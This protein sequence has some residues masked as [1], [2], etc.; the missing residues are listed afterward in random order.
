MMKVWGKVF[1][2]E[3][4]V[5]HCVVEVNP[6]VST[7]FDMIKNVCESL[8]I[9]TPVILKKHVLDFNQFSMTLFKPTDFV[10]NFVFDRVII[11][12]LSEE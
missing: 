1:K 8:D 2:G 9:P 5:N 4:I 7:F 12:Y 10:E 6:S 11:E 3:K